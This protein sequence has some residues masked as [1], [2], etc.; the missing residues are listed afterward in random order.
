MATYYYRGLV[1]NSASD[2]GYPRDGYVDAKSNK[3]A[4]VKIAA[5]IG[6]WFHDSIRVWN[7]TSGKTVAESLYNQPIS[8]NG[9]KY[10]WIGR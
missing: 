5:E 10:T 8:K 4:L 1:H 2:G 6:L 9:E 3:D 7:G